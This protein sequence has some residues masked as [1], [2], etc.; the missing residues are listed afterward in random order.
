M[1]TDAIHALISM[2][3]LP[4]LLEIAL[5]AVF[6]V[7]AVKLVNVVGSDLWPASWPLALQVI[8]AM[9]VSQFGEY[10]IHRG[11]HEVPFLWRFMP[12]IIV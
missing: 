12:C 2:I 1:K 3:V 8:F 10:W 4:Q 11:M 9:L 6:L 5:R 7:V